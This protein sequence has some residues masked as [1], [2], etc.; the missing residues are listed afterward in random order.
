MARKD[1]AGKHIGRIR[2]LVGSRGDGRGPDSRRRRVD[3]DAHQVRL[4]QEMSRQV[5]V[6]VMMENGPMDEI[7]VADVVHELLE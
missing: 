4:R 1:R 5:H 7:G 6:N 3:E 2:R